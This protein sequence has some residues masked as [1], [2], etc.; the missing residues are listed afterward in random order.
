MNTKQQ[1]PSVT[2]IGL[3]PMG[4]AMVRAYLRKG[5]AV[6]VW[7]RTPSRAEPLVAE[8][9]VLAASAEEALAANELVVL[10]LTD[11]A[12]MYALL[13]PAAHALRGRT[14]ANLSSDTPERAREAAEW[15]TGHGARYLTAGVAVSPAQVGTPDGYAYY[16]GPEELVEEHRDALEVLSR[17][18]YRGE[19]QGRAAL[20]YQVQMDLFW[21]SMTAWLHSVAVAEANGVSAE[22]LLPDAVDTAASLPYFFRFY[23]PRLVAGNIE[24]DAERLSMGVASMEHVVDTARSAGVDPS[25]PSAVLGAFRRAMDAGHAADSFTSVRRVLHAPRGGTA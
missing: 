1:Q 17:I 22:E 2:V 19:D 10:S 7:N 9:A 14:V 11:C 23:T 25:L 13:G 5:Y 20:H 21:T 8:G 6:T 3:G 16:S 15:A 18:E 12:A 24:G 4:Q